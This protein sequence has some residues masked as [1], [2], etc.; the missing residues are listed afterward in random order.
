VVAREAIAD[1]DALAM[2]AY[3]NGVLRQENNTCNLIRPVAQLISDVTEFMTLAAGD[4]LLVGVPEDP[5][6]AVAGD[7]IAVEIDGVGRLENV[8]VPELREQERRADR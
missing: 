8:L 2:R 3:V 1:P 7:R 6:A 4:V 5:P